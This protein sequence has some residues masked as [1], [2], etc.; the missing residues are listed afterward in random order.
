[1]IDNLKTAYLT[2][3]LVVLGIAAACM[4]IMIAWP[5]LAYLSSKL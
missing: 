3:L 5:A 4:A 2:T 1:M